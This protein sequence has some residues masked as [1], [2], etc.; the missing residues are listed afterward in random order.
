MLHFFIA[1]SVLFQHWNLLLQFKNTLNDRFQI[2][3][4][5]IIAKSALKI[6]RVGW[7][8]SSKS[9]LTI[10]VF[11]I[12]FEADFHCKLNLGYFENSTCL[13]WS[14]GAAPVKWPLLLLPSSSSSSP[15]SPSPAP[16]SIWS[17]TLPLLLL[18][19][20]PPPTPP[21]WFAFLLSPPTPPPTLTLTAHDTSAPPLT[22]ICLPALG[23]RLGLL[24]ISLA[25]LCDWLLCSPF[26]ACL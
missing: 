15:S 22:N 1:N 4:L 17:I 8:L 6:D 23:G 19:S 20:L 9:L 16:S 5:W 26:F 21:I 10:T 11:W 18:L 13:K 24:V 7:K 12:F 25:G 14:S 3:Q 2:F